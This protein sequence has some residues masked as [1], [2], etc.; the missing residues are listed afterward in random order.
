MAT[1][2]LV[3]VVAFLL[4]A[5]VL[6]RVRLDRHRRA[7]PLRIAVTGTRGKSGVSRL[8]AAVLREHGLVVVAKTTGAAAALILP[9]GSEH[10]IRRRG[11]PSILEQKRVVRTAAELGADVLVAEV[12]SIHPEN[13]RV[14][15][16]HLLQPHIVVATNF[17]VDHTAAAG[18]TRAAVAALLA[19]DVAAGSRVFVPAAEAEPVFLA[20][21]RATPAAAVV[22]P[23]GSSEAVVPAGAAAARREFRDNLDLVHAVAQS[24]HIPDATVRAGVGRAR[25]DIGGLRVWRTPPPADCFLVNAFAANDPDSTMLVWDR[26]MARLDAAPDACLGLLLLRA[27]R[28]DRTVQWIDA[29]AAGLLDRFRELVVCGAHAHVLRRRLRRAAATPVH[30]LRAT[31]AAAIMD[32]VR[33]RVRSGDVVFGFG[34]IGG[35]GADLVADWSTHAEP[36]EL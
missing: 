30:A 32:E 7:I 3:L 18:T 22:V 20:R 5:L 1:M 9:D 36:L 14:E 28:A 24:L 23:A 12:M 11:R 26:V 27:D 13:H 25:H 4:G 29:L 17:R 35:A 8:L 34:N 6:E 15:T 2:L 16:R 31:D 33:A 21:V 19:L 10:P